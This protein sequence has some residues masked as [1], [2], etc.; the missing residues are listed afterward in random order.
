MEKCYGPNQ[1][2][3]LI[4]ARTS[5]C[6]CTTLPPPTILSNISFHYL[7]CVFVFYVISVVASSFVIRLHQDKKTHVKVKQGSPVAVGTLPEQVDQ[8]GEVR[9]VTPP[10]QRNTQIQAEIF[11][12]DQLQTN[13]V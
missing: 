12:S 10:T 9:Q 13:D 7:T 6:Q 3:L 11:N 8:V 2:M 5:F 1:A 4:T